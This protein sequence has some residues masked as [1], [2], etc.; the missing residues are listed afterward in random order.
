MIVFH[1][2]NKIIQ[3]PDIIHSRR[4]VDFGQGFYTTNIL[5]QAKKWCQKF[6]R[7]GEDAYISKFEYNEEKAKSFKQLN[8][9][10]YDEAWL[11][12]VLNCRKEKDATDYD[13]V[14][15]GVANDKVFNTVELFFDGLIDKAEALRR[16]KFEK[17]NFQ[18]CFRSQSAIDECL[19]FLENEK[20]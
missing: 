10:S 15:G 8:F 3:K 9:N 5:P 7:L 1:G 2:S 14:S 19:V 20:L 6:I 17:P 11:D 13:I 4:N 16:L 18:I 12:F